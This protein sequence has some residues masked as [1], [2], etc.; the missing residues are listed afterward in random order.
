[1]TPSEKKDYLRRRSISPFSAPF[2][3]IPEDQSVGQPLEPNIRKLQ[4][5]YWSKHDPDGR[6][7]VP[8]ADALRRAGDFIEAHRVLREGL[9]R[10]P[11]FISGHVV[12]GWLSLDRGRPEKAEGQFQTALELDPRNIAAL[13]AM[14]DILLQR[15]ELVEALEVLEKLSHE[16]PID[17][18]LPRQ[19]A[20]LRLQ[21]ESAPEEGR[22]EEAGD[23]LLRVWND[24]HAVV[25]ELDW[26]S[27]TL[28]AD[29]S[30]KRAQEDRGIEEAPEEAW[31]TETPAPE[32]TGPVMEDGEPLPGDEGLKGAVMTTTLGEIYL[33]QGFLDQAEEV[34][35]NLLG[36]DPESVH[37]QQRLAE[38]RGL[39]G[40]RGRM[41]EMD[42]TSLIEEEEETWETIPQEPAGVSWVESS[43]GDGLRRPAV[44]PIESLAPD[45]L[46]PWKAEEVGSPGPSAPDEPISIDALA[47]DESVSIEALAPDEPI[48]IDALA[49]DEPI[50]IDALAP[51][52]PISIDALAPDEPV[53]IDALAP[54]E[55][56]SIDSLAPDE[57]ISIHALAPDEALS[58]DA[59]ASNGPRGDSTIADFERWLEGLK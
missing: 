51:D 59:T 34:F 29:E 30:P 19:I 33:R 25:E 35:E 41:G 15:G 14:G 4:E 9:S 49:P 28:Q 39:K 16:D 56:I 24:P 17:L 8:L 42:S 31:G 6:G 3:S 46:S 54:D 20:E 32:E 5:F 44:V 43:S 2:S 38:V 23:S 53:S 13:R 45:R 27:A 10:H 52:E 18:S 12:A 50:S 40:V 58:S 21:A 22:G 47:P 48:S 11:D 1:L 7:F 57:P 36:E 37:L 26:G 55:P